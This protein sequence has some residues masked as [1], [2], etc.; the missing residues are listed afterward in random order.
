LTSDNRKPDAPIDP[1][2][3]KAASGSWLAFLGGK[4]KG[5]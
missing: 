3:A 2:A 5:K 1:A 4:G